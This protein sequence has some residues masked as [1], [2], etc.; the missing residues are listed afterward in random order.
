MHALVLARQCSETCRVEFGLIWDALVLHRLTQECPVPRRVMPSNNLA[1]LGEQTAITVPG[2]AGVPR[3]KDEAAD[4][5]AREADVQDCLHD[6]RHRDGCSGTDRDHEGSARRSEPETGRALELRN[7]ERK[8][9]ARP[10]RKSPV[11]G[12][13]LLAD[14]DGEG[15]A[16][17]HGDPDLGHLGQDRGFVSITVA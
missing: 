7:A 15:K 16:R 6:P 5:L 12:A 10:F 8:L 1:E 2:E 14:L 11:A 13:G 9:G 17:G 3:T 4:G